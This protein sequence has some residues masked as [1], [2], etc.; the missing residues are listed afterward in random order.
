[1]IDEY[2]VDYDEYVGIGS[3]ALSFL[4]GRVYANTFSLAGVRTTRPRRAPGGRRAPGRK[5]AQRDMMRYR[6]V[7]DLFGLRLDK[8]RFERDFGVPVERALWAEMSFMRAAGAFE[9]RRR[10]VPH[11][12]ADGPLP[13]RRHDA[14]DAHRVE[15]P[16]RRGARGAARSRS[17]RCCSSAAAFAPV[18]PGSR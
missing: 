17:G 3:G 1:M 7:T 6:F 16:A 13:A 11:A 9:R 12:H 2:I 10:R 5:Y 4:D 18:E 14:R 8:R 15:P